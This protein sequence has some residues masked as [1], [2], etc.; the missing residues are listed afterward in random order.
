MRL[1]RASY[2]KTELLMLGMTVV[3]GGG[4]GYAAVRGA[5]GIPGF[6][7]VSRDHPVAFWSGVAFL[8]SMS[9]VGFLIVLGGALC[10]YDDPR[11]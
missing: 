5:L 11:R 10:L 8:G 3:C 1:H 9:L 4:A 2:W 6:A 7:I